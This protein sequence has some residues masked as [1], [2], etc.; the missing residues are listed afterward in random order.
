MRRR[1]FITLLG[2]AAVAWPVAARAQ[3]PAKTPRIGVLRP[4]ALR[5]PSL[6]EFVRSLR[7]L[8]YVENQNVVIE[9][10]VAEGKV[11]RLRPLASE[12]L[13]LKVD[14]IVAEHSSAIQAAQQ[15]TRT[16]P[17]VMAASAD[18][19][20]AGLVASLA[21]PG[22]NV[23]GLS[24]LAPEADEKRLELLK[25]TLPALKRV[26]FIWDPANPGLSLRFKAVDMAGRALVLEIQSLEVRTPNELHGALESATRKGA[27][28]LVVPSPMVSAY[29]RQIVDFAA[30][31][32]LPLVYDGR[33]FVE[34]GGVLMSYGSNLTDLWHRAGVYVDKIL[35]GAKPADLPVEQPTKFELVINLKTA[36][37]L[38]LDVPPMLLA[39]AD[40]V[41]E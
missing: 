23:T 10:R 24:R 14:I 31:K 12:L 17:I 9:Y 32:R 38:G 27:G 30:K 29:R 2:G 13:D 39:R 40:E 7:E 41:I 25:E 8:G 1:E 34:E 15:V 20:G 19:V 33:E 11:D 37:A 6:D 18:P 35:K 4:G 16:I 5:D 28:A 36:K 26:A 3:Q 22:G 21:R